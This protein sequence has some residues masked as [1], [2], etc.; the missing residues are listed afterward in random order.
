[1]GDMA[2]LDIVAEARQLSLLPFQITG[3]AGCGS[4]C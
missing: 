2:H 3:L 4:K 1:M